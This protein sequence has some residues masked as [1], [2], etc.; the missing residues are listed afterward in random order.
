MAVRKRRLTDANVARLAPAAREYTV[1]DTRHVGLGVRIRPSGHR[2]FV[3]CRKGEDGACR[4]TLGSAALMSVEEARRS[5]LAIE[6]GAR[7]DRTERDAVPTF[8]DFVAGPG[9][10]CIDPKSGSW[11][12]AGLGES[13]VEWEDERI[14]RGPRGSPCG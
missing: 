8:E 14:E 12:R 3:Y 13:L 6:T 11:A 10:T 1:W 5:C 4:I 7:P 9:R 2:S